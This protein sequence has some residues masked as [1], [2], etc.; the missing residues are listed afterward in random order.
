MT[1]LATIN[2]I[3]RIMDLGEKA[4][5]ASLVKTPLDRLTA[6]RYLAQAINDKTHVVY[7][8]EKDGVVVGFIIGVV[9]PYWF[10]KS[11]FATDLAFY[12]EPQHGNFAPFLVRRFM[13]WAKG[14]KGVL[15]VTMGVTSGVAHADRIG[16]M[17]EK[18]G[19]TPVGGSFTKLL[20]S[21]NE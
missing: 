1:R 14:Q 19:M 17:F 6:R 5:E 4:I 15:D 7:V 20:G 18:L 10:S 2:D 3:T 9:V 21:N 13:K 16:V 11:R 8:A 12:C